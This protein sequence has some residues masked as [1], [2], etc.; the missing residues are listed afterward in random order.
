MLVPLWINFVNNFHKLNLTHGVSTFWAID[1][2]VY[3]KNDFLNILL[4]E[5]E[6]A[7]EGNRHTFVNSPQ[8]LSTAAK[9]ILEKSL[10]SAH[11]QDFYKKNHRN[12]LFA[13]LFVSLATTIKND[14][15]FQR[16]VGTA[17]F[18][19][20]HIRVVKRQINWT[21]PKSTSF[22]VIY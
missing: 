13:T 15:G 11:P 9:I 12:Q 16:I 2:I 17:N 20:Q 7:T 22:F 5:A 6:E 21:V 14:V 19:L 8:H 18:R 1:S 10:H 3:A 4:S